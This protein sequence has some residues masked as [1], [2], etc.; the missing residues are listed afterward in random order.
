MKNL[1]SN[2]GAVTEGLCQ[3]LWFNKKNTIL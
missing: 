2:A 3:F 1:T